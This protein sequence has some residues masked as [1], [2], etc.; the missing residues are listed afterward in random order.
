M[1]FLGIVVSLGGDTLR[2]LLSSRQE[3]ISKN[4]QQAEERAKEAKQ[5]VLEAK[6]QLEKAQKKAV[7][8][9]EQGKSNSRQREERFC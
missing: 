6:S 9:N 3:G 7:E 4:L 1:L 2:S 8:I 5:R